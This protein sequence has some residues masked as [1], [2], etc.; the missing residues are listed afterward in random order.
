VG[1]LLK[2]EFRESTRQE[3]VALVARLRDEAGVE[4]VILGGTEL[5]L[6][7]RTPEIAGLPALDTTGLHVAAIVERLRRGAISSDAPAT[8]S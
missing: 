5:P 1:E 3:I 4:G 6:L 7:L 2:G 8:T